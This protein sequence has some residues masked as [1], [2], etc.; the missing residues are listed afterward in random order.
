MIAKVVRNRARQIAMEEEF[1]VKVGVNDLF[2]I[3]GAGRG[4]TKYDNNDVAGVVVGEA[5][6]MQAENL[7][8]LYYLFLFRKVHRHPCYRQSYYRLRKAVFRSLLHRIWIDGSASMC[9][10]SLRPVWPVALLFHS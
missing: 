1:A 7:G 3:L 6:Q 8:W 4:R 5:I 2:D 10:G 9:N